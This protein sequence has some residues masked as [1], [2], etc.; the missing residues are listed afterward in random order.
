VK[1][2]MIAPLTGPA[3]APVQIGW[4]NVNDYLSYFEKVGVPGVTLPP[5]VTIE[6]VWTDSGLDAT[7]ATSAYE[8]MWDVVFFH[9]FTPVE[10]HAVRS[11]LERDGIA[12]MVMVVD[13]AMMYPPGQ[14]FTVY[15]TESESFAVMCDW[16]M[17]N[18][19][20][21]RPP[22]VA[23]MGLDSPLGRALEVMGKAYAKDVGI[24]ILPLEVVPYTALDMSPYLLRV[25]ERRADYVH[26]LSNWVTAV[27]ILRDA[28]RL[29]LADK[30]RFGGFENSQAIALLELGPVAEGY[31]SPRRFP[32]YK[33]TPILF[34]I[35]GEYQGRI[36]TEGDGAAM[37]VVVPVMI[38]AIRIAIEEVG[39]ENL[40][41]RAVKEAM[42]SIKDF[43][44]HDIGRP[45]T[46]TPED[47]RGRPVIRIYEVQGGEVV[48]VSDWRDAP[49]LVP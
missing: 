15:P 28:E 9:L 43:D 39:Y 32:W 22:R 13:E 47:H 40:D 7:R 46:Y 14:L 10:T 27:A 49:M 18:W 36:D 42:Y 20:E 11:R 37:L 16:I 8:R 44:P 21:E 41:G 23:I 38:E 31:L 24:E 12:A 19:Q 45:V 1:I 6:L 35:F 26:I 2:G 34:D 25:A 3:A 4:R 5:G 48:P 17:E 33:E 29:G 30:M